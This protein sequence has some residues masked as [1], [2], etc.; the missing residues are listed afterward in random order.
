[1]AIL[2]GDR[3]LY[4]SDGPAAGTVLVKN[5]AGAKSANS[6]DLT[7]AGGKLFFSA[8]RTDSQRELFGS[9]GTA[10]GTKLVKKSFGK[11]EFKSDAVVL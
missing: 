4:V 7:V 8:L 11:H 10:A 3:E 5:L 9:D 1:M 6:Q 2:G